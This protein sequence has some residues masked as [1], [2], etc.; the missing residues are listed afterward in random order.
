MVAIPKIKP[1]NTKTITKHETQ[2]H[3]SR[4]QHCQ[5]ALRAM[6]SSKHMDLDVKNDSC[7]HVVRAEW[8]KCA[9]DCNSN[10]EQ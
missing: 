10:L 7:S 2:Q 5:D 6:R 8:H 9:C 3:T 1:H 4:K